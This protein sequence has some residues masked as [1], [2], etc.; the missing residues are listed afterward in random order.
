MR[1]TQARLVRPQDRWPL[2]AVAFI[3]AVSAVWWGL[4]LFAPPGTPEWLE[5]ARA[6]CFNTT[7]S[8]LPD[9]K[10]WLL[11]I[12]QPPA[13]LLALY[14]GWS[15]QVRDTFRHLA[16]SRTGRR[17]AAGVGLTVLIFLA[18]AAA[19]AAS[20]RLPPP[21]LA[22]SFGFGSERVE[23]LPETYPRLDRPWPGTDGLV[24]QRG[25]AFTLASLE[26]RPA[27]VTFAF[28]HC[29][30]ICPVLVRNS[31]HA[32]RTAER[33]VAVVALTLDPWRDT[34][35][36]L[37]TLAD[38]Y[39]LDPD[40]DFLAGGTPEAVTAALDAFGIAYDRNTLTGDVVHPPL[41]YLVEADGTIAYASGGAVPH[42]V[43][44]AHRLWAP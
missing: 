10:G 3:A 4:A 36:R 35:S 8:G 12:G 6:V 14:A 28:G 44:L 42:L 38:G 21:A 26:G 30:T 2:G 15:N 25:D 18:T 16:A 40:R 13:M 20:L 41:V 19:R 5:R 32:R 9:A 7:E 22:S 29:Q 33:D 43:Q 17:L 27:F 11:L 1:A 23:A 31:L 37:P 24:D 34:P 39:G